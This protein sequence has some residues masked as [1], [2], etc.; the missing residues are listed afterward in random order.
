MTCT[1]TVACMEQVSFLEASRF[2]QEQ[3]G[4]LRR[5]NG[6]Q[7]GGGGKVQQFQV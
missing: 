7:W 6:A 1:A 5:S 3:A 4:T 2:A